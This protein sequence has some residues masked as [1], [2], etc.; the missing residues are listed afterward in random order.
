MPSYNHPM[1]SIL[2]LIMPAGK[3]FE[4]AAVPAKNGYY[5]EF[6]IGG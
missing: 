1:W 3:Y 2:N 4:R 5:F 6:F